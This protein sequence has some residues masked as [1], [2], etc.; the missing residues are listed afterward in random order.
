M[1]L[2]LALNGVGVRFVEHHQVAGRQRVVLGLG[3]EVDGHERRLGRLVCHHAHLR[4]AGDHV[5]AHVARH[6][7]LRRRHVGVA[8]AGDLVH[9]LDGLRAVGQRTDGLRAAH[10]VDFR[11]ARDAAGLQNGRVQRAVLRGRRDA[12]DAPHPGHGGRQ[13]V[14]EHG[15]RVERTAPR[16][17]DAHRVQRRHLRAHERAVLAHEE[18]ALLLLAFVELP[19]LARGV[20]Q[21]VRRLR[22]QTAGG[23][24]DGLLR[25]AERPRAH[26]VELL[27]EVAQ[28][29][30]AAGAHLFDDGGGR[31]EGCGVERA[32]AVDGR[33][34]ELL[35]GL[36]DD[37][38]HRDSFAWSG[39][40]GAAFAGA[41]V[42]GTDADVGFAA[43]MAS[44]GACAPP[45]TGS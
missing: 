34:G 35:A 31:R 3:H 12:H 15:G 29:R 19:D 8:R 10:R 36:E 43:A 24:V 32:R 14:H 17:V 28:G 41:P 21:G 1:P 33:G 40:R 45:G 37:A 5:D 27:R 22:V 42:A 39:G 13:G 6:D 9:R 16:H 4:R 26:A 20:R 18:P 25:H 2:H 23:L 7:L 30:V 44:A 11:D 38:S